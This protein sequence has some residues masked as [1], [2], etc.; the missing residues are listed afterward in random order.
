L[1][2][3][4]DVDVEFAGV[5]REQV[6]IAGDDCVGV[7]GSGERDNVV[8]VGIA[9]DRWVRPWWVDQQGGLGGQIGDEPNGLLGGEVLP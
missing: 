3:R 8:V 7:A 9:T 6:E 1:A 2:G 4:D 5:D